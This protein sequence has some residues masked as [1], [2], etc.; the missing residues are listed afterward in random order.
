MNNEKRLPLHRHAVHIVSGSGGP[1]SPDRPVMSRMLSPTELLI[2]IVDIIFHVL[3]FV[4]VE[5]LYWH[6]CN[7]HLVAILQ[8][9]E[10]D[11]Q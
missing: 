7:Y 10:T 6:I 5:L 8:L 4:Y 11:G 1:R 9:A 3:L 2:L